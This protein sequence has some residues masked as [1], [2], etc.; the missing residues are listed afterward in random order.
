MS[1]YSQ[2]TDKEL[3]ELLKLND[4]NA[5]NEIYTRYWK[6]ML[7]VAWN[8]SKDQFIAKDIVQEVF[9]MLW[10]KHSKLNIDN[11]ASY[12]STSIKFLVFKNHQKELRRSDLAKENYSFQEVIFD[13]EQLDA[14]FLQD[15]INDVVERMP[16]R[17]R[18]VFH[19]SRNLG[20][21]NYEIAEKINIAEKS[22]EKNLT[23]AL[24]IIRGE[25]KNHGISVIVMLKTLLFLFR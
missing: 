23:R 13:E 20:L 11:L 10:E 18:L 12:L 1:L 8:H 3:L 14:R 17:C 16:E 5:F 22:V 24:K 15:F 7:L 2:Y 4:R 25:L 19:C 6:K 9:V 21:K